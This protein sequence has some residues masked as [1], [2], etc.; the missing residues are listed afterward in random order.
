[1]STS[2]GT[3]AQF[4][5]IRNFKAFDD[6]KHKKHILT[7]YA[8]HLPLDLPL[9][10]NA[11]LPNVI[12]NKTC[13]EMRKTLL[14][15]PEHFLL[16]NSG[17]ICTANTFEERKQDGNEHVVHMQFDAEGGIV[18]GGHSYAQLIHFLQGDNTYSHEKEL[19]ALLEDDADGDPKIKELIDDKGRFDAALARARDK[20]QVQIEVIVPV[21]S[22][23]LLV[24]ISTARNR[25]MPVDETGF[26]N[27]AGRFDIMKEVLRNS[28][29]PFGPAYV[30]DVVVW[31]PNQEVGEDAKAVAVKALVQ[32]MALMNIARYPSDKP[33]NEVYMR[34]GL[35]IREFADPGEEEERVY[36]GLMRLLPDLIRLHE[37]M[38]ES[39]PETNQTFPWADGKDNPDKAKRKRVTT[40][41]FLNRQCPTKVASAFLWP[42]FSAFR[43][44]LHWKA[45]GT[46][47]FK[48]DPIAFF[49][50]MKAQLV[51][52]VINFHKRV[53]V[54][55]QVGKD[56]EVWVRLDGV[57]T[58]ELVIQERLARQA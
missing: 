9:E 3:S 21:D 16:L 44:L 11:R 30:K 27:L 55:N 26:Q 32:L 33:A 4:P 7:V 2:T 40:T 28:P 46:L 15:E 58:G 53:K 13:R 47:A 37:H 22:T 41:P 31:K 49:D 54:V 34:A 45:D 36:Q 20:A 6:G 48:V 29:L 17:I 5:V 24:E 38:Y 50:D 56:K 1:M 10:A 35:V 42:I 8:R 43:N 18:N 14:L 23:D 12:R 25:S 52:P 57:V 39:L 51:T 19:L